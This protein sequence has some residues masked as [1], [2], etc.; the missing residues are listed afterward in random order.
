M[1]IPFDTLR[2]QSG[3]GDP[4]LVPCAEIT[5][6]WRGS[7]FSRAKQLTGMYTR[8]T[9]ELGPSFR[10]YE[11]GSMSNAR[12]I[13][14]D[15]LE[16]VPMWLAS[17][18][19]RDIFMMNLESGAK[20]NVPSDIALQFITD[21]EEDVPVGALRICLPPAVLTDH[22]EEFVR[23]VVYFLGDLDF[24]SGH[25]GIGVN[26]DPRGDDAI[27]AKAAM[28]NLAARMHAVDFYDLAVTFGAM[29]K[30]HPAGIKR[31]SWLTLLGAPLLTM[32][33]GKE[34]FAAD[35]PGTC[36][37]LPLPGGALVRAGV[38][39]MLGSPNLQDDL[40]PYKAVGKRLAAFR[41]R[42][43]GSIFAS[44]AQGRQNP[45]RLWLGRFDQ[46]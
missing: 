36:E 22:R 30:T 23:R 3:N 29:R 7:M 40:S 16:T 9:N 28:M 27:E 44:T 8:I 42:D 6:Y 46:D 37:V 32:L 11:T 18:P 26:W 10:F 31:V 25:A 45:T 38:F 34:A 39:P 2:H 24:E 5:V 19:R 4:L 21:E 41:F 12:P 35:L 33:G 17:K 14:Q 15:T 20:K 1:D 13:R 43:H